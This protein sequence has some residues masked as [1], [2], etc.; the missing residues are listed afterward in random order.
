MADLFEIEGS[1]I[2]CEDVGADLDDDQVGAAHD[3][4]S[5]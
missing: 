1:I 5:Q 4:L 3:L 2:R